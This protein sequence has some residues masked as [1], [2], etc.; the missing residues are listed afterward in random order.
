MKSKLSIKYWV[1]DVKIIYIAEYMLLVTLIGIM[2]LEN[3]RHQ[4]PIGKLLFLLLGKI[5]LRDLGAEI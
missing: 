2:R 5:D 4:I 3:K 1:L